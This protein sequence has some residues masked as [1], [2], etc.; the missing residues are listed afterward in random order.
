VL[1]REVGKFF[2]AMSHEIFAR[3]QLG[4]VVVAGLDA[5]KSAKESVCGNVGKNKNRL[6]A[7]AR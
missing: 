4:L 6:R 3:D 7:R 1:E 2:L 5:L